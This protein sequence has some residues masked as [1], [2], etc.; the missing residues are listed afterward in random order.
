GAG[1]ASSGTGARRILVTV[2]LALCL[3]LMVGS[4]LF[5]STLVRTLRSDLGFRPDGVALARFD[6]GSLGYGPDD[7]LALLERIRGRLSSLPEVE[8]VGWASRV[9][10]QVGGNTATFGT[11]A[12]YQP[13]PDEEIR[14]EYIL[15]GPGLLDALGIDL[16][17]GR[18][19]LASPSDE[20][21]LLVNPVMVQRYWASPEAALGG[22]VMLGGNAFAVAGITGPVR[23]RDVSG[24]PTN[25]AVVPGSLVPS[26]VLGAPVTLAVRTRGD[27]ARLLP[28]L[29][30][31]LRAEE[32]DLTFY[33]VRTADSMLGDALA[34]QRLGSLVFS[35]FAFLALV[36]AATGIGG[37]VA[38]AMTRRR[39]EIGIRLAL[40]APEGRVVRSAV[41]SMAPPVLAGLV[42]GTLAS[43]LVGRTLDAFL[44]GAGAE[45]PLVYAAAGGVLVAVAAVSALWPALGA[46]RVHPVEVLR[47]E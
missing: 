46:V 23:W 7:G 41:L 17:R 3:L 29:R 34:P 4:G 20:P 5:L 39:R 6:P 11:I 27:A 19:P 45:D 13:A 30:R 47:Q 15:G 26:L 1:R 10:L 24:D 44:L 36:L 9:P 40:G 21:A 16:S 28:A 37:I 31:E 22:S 25:Y 43:L 32:P 8:A 14:I 18:D 38:Y 42:A 33:F 2:Q 12:G 35:A